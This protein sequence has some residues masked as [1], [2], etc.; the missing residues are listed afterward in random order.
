ME[1]WL[2]ASFGKVTN[3]EGK[4]PGE[5]ASRHLGTSGKEASGIRG[6]W[7]PIRRVARAIPGLLTILGRLALGPGPIGALRLGRLTR[8]TEPE[9]M[10]PTINTLCWK[11]KW[12][13]LQNNPS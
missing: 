1:S 11:T 9:P 13:P 8:G 12:S 6:A 10:V 5:E 2:V 7:A 3:R 4:R